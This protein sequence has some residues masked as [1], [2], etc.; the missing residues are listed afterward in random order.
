[1][2]Q[3]SKEIVQN[4]DETVEFL[5]TEFQDSISDVLDQLIVAKKSVHDLALDFEACQSIAVD[6]L[7]HSN[8]ETSRKVGKANEDLFLFLRLQLS[9]IKS[10][11]MYVSCTGNR[12]QYIQDT[13]TT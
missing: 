7:V 13:M 10:Y 1:M 4:I 9:K 8:S 6:D 5:N 12:L 11:D 3:D 2:T